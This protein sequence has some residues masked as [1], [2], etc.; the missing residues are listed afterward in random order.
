MTE[1]ILVSLP[2]QTQ[3]DLRSSADADILPPAQQCP[4]PESDL[5]VD[6]LGV[7]RIVGFTDGVP[8][9]LMEIGGQSCLATAVA[10][11]GQLSEATDIGASVCLAFDRGD[12]FRPIVLGRITTRLVPPELPDTGTHITDTREIVLQCGK[13]SISLKADGTVAIRGTNVA[14]RATHTNRIRGGNVQIN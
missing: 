14:S 3:I 12:A 4:A 8:R 9:V 11:N 10:V 2:S 5:R 13:A 1:S 6:G 7:G